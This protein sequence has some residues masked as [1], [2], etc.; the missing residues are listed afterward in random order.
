MWQAFEAR[1]HPRG[2]KLEVDYFSDSNAFK[3]AASVISTR[4]FN[5]GSRERIF[6]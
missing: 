4:A 5:E 2:R 3:A 6:E 1:K